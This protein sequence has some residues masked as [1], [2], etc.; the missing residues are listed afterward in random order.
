MHAVMLGFLLVFAVVLVGFAFLSWIESKELWN[1]GMN[2]ETG[3]P[4]IVIEEGG[5]LFLDDGFRRIGVNGLVVHS[6]IVDALRKQ[7]RAS[8]KSGAELIKEERQRQISVKGYDLAHD[9]E[10]REEELLRAACAYEIAAISTDKNSTKMP[11]C[12]PF[13][14]QWWKPAG[15]K[16]NFIKAGA[17]YQAEA[18]RLERLRIEALSKVKHC[19][20][21]IDSL[22]GGE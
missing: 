6:C 11:K 22:L 2:R 12:W 10:H 19:A 9:Y 16:R 14:S 15:T 20:D 3:R 1:G 13:E 5:K 18:D 8:M 21:S 4:W 7:R 17:L